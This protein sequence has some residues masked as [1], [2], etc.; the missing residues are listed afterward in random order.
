[1]EIKKETHIVTVFKI[2]E[3][4]T[5]NERL[6]VLIPHR[7]KF[8][9]LENGR[10]RSSENVN[11]D[12]NKL[13]MDLENGS[14]QRDENV[15][16]SPLEAYEK[17]KKFCFAREIPIAEMKKNGKRILTVYFGY[18]DDELNSETE[19]F[20]AYKD[21]YTSELDEM[22][23]Y[24]DLDDLAP[25]VFWC[26]N[27]DFYTLHEYSIDHQTKTLVNR[28]PIGVSDDEVLETK[29]M[30]ERAK[31]K[32][33]KLG[34][35]EE[36]VI[37]D[38]KEVPSDK[39][40][41]RL[42]LIKHLRQCFIAQDEPVERI[43]SAVYNPIKL[44]STDFKR[45]ILIYGP[46]GSG[47]TA[48]VKEIAKELGLPFFRADLSGFSA[49]GYVGNS[50]DSI[51]VGLY[52]AADRDMQKLEQGAILFLDEVDKLIMSDE[53][54]VKSQVYNELLTLLDPGGVVNFK[55]STLGNSMTYDKRNLI[56]ITAGSFG[57]LTK[58][59]KQKQLNKIGYGVQNENTSK[60]LTQHTIKDFTKFGI[61]IEF[62]GRHQLIINL[63]GLTEEDLFQILTK[64][65]YSP[66]VVYK[67]ELSSRGITLNIPESTLR[68]IASKAYKLQT[69]ARSLAAIFNEALEPELN[70][71][72][73][74]LDEGNTSE[75]TINV[76]EKEIVKRLERYH[77]D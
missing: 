2:E 74:R 73:D 9:V 57:E 48:I 36:R 35:A 4:E 31:G 26:N 17:G 64:A 16:Y 41:T 10:F 30:F 14:S 25:S 34:E 29:R 33:A 20:E 43:A 47:K 19:M 13:I 54:D 75:I 66:Y 22:V 58:K 7:V 70:T 23:W 8:G 63:K 38:L 27:I 60:S 5:E 52:S 51:Y 56:I 18:E 6:L 40:I 61:P 69:G 39:R 46:T 15:Y 28:K 68:L 11:Y 42:S 44:G 55:T 65:L 32:R 72:V 49:A 77:G 59:K 37:T 21:A 3:L 24:I 12:L 50:V 53:K 62:L 45:N 67:R 76:D 71:I 1:M